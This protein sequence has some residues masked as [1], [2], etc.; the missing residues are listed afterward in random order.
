MFRLGVSHLDRRQPVW[1][2]RR[3]LQLTAIRFE[4]RDNGRL[5][6]VDCTQSHDDRV[7]ITIAIN[8]N[9]RQPARLHLQSTAD[10]RCVPF[11]IV[12]QNPSK[13]R[14]IAR[15]ADPERG[16]LTGCEILAFSTHSRPPLQNL[17]MSEI[18]SGA[19]LRHPGGEQDALGRFEAGPC[20]K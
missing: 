4:T 11:A 2:H 6:E 1:D 16:P 14:N 8:C 10:P 20:S 19:D 18:V 15:H 5:S 9:A 13:T 3:R 17:P 12:E 7:R